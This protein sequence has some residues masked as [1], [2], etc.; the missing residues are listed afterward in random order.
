MAYDETK[1]I[2]AGDLKIA[3]NRIKIYVDESIANIDFGPAGY[4]PAGSTSFE[5]LPTAGSTNLGAV[6]NITNSFTTTEAFL[7]GAGVSYPA[8]TDVAVVKDGETYK[9]NVYVGSTG[10]ITTAVPEEA[11]GK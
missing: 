9:Y 8:G 2:T 6:Y 11:D 5:N 3:L 4:Y 1:K 10:N 7:E